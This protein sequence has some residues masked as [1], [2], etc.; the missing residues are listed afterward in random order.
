LRKLIAILVTLCVCVCICLAFDVFLASLVVVKNIIPPLP[1]PIQQVEITP[2]VVRTPVSEESLSM[3]E[4]L[5]QTAIPAR[6]LYSLTERLKHTGPVPR[7]VNDAP[8]DYQVGDRETF[9]VNDE[10]LS[11]TYFTIEATLRYATSHLYMWVEDGLQLDD[12]DIEASANEFEDQIYPT[13]RQY[14]GSEWSP[15]VDNDVHVHILNANL[16]S[17]GGYYSSNDEHPSIVNPFSNEK[18][19][20]YINAMYISPGNDIYNSILA[21][22]FQH[23]IHWNVDPNED[24]W[25]NEGSA[26]TAEMLNGYEPWISS[27][28]DVPDTQLTAWADEIEEAGVHYDVSLL[29]MYYFTERFGAELVREL[30]ATEADG[31]VGFDKVLAANGFDITFD[32]IFK[33]WLIANYLNDPYLHDGSY[34]YEGIDLWDTV[35]SDHMH[36]HYPDSR[37]TTVYQYAADYIDLEPGRGDLAIEFQGSTQVNLVDNAPHSGEYEWWSNRGDVSNMTLTRKFDFSD[38]DEA[39]LEYWLWYD[40]EDDYDYAYVEVSSDGGR[41]WDILRSEQTTD[42]NPYGNNFGYGYTGISGGGD[43]PIW[44]KEEID[45]TPYVG[46]E[47]MIRFEYI[48]D[49]AYNDPGLCLDDIA[50][51]E[52]GYS[53]DA[54]TDGGWEA[55]G[56][57]R[58][59]NILPQEWIV[60]VIEFGAE[61]TVEEME[62]GE[63]EEGRLVI[64]DFGDDVH[65]AVLV[66]AALAPATTE[67]ASYE[68]SVYL[69][70]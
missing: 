26:Q 52:L 1:T 9:W 21:H 28:L 8:P 63:T 13:N 65:R 10:E 36:R 3:V 34:G 45:L 12:E 70:E 22:E 39:T 68:Y 35:A 16:P 64:E 29:F 58:S 47:V 19:I 17:V 32:D 25:V 48:T 37:S 33:D 2:T 23:M 11:D 49:D 42:T 27:F 14:F 31:I 54:E 7:V 30:T 53:Y 6:D 38:L 56:F 61:T 51:P 59:N 4:L 40:I 18:E 24:T 44:V 67:I 66:I 60:Q 46:Q 69:T 50:I 41:T 62:L 57:I 55:E 20:M 5:R 43:E 15:G